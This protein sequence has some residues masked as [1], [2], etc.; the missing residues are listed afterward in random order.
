MQ[1]IKREERQVIDRGKAVSLIAL[2]VT[3][4]F[5]AHALCAEAAAP[6]RKAPIVL[7]QAEGSNGD[8]AAVGGAD[9][10]GACAAPHEYVDLINAGKYNEIGGLFA[11][12][13]VYMG[14]DGKT[15]YGAKEIGNFYTQF[16]GILKPRVKPASFIQDGDNCIMELANR[17]KL[18]GKYS[19]VAIDHFTIDGQGKIS[20]FIVYLRP[21][22]RFVHTM[23]AALAKV[24]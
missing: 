11:D 15:R 6:R 24:H 4:G 19:L 23:D 9:S 22:A 1:A 3:V 16:L 14:P 21:G 5:A 20:R 10:R 8:S 18:S 13:A 7:A 12:D 17:N 2:A